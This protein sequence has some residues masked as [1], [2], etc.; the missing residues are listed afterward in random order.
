MPE[1]LA[2]DM[3]NNDLILNP[4]GGVERVTDGR[5]VV[6]NV[7]SKLRTVLGEYLLNRELGWI[8]LEDFVKSYDLFDLE[9]RARKIILETEGV[10]SI[11]FMNLDV[12]QR[13]LTLTFQ[14]NTIYG[15]ID[16]TIPWSNRI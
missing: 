5:F 8:N 4:N 1:Q 2:L 14:A 12:S 3:T 7:R 10:S 11:E 9:D 6:Q 13:T 15:V 16:V